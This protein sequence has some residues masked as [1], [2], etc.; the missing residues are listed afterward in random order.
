MSGKTRRLCAALL[1]VYRHTLPA[2]ASVL[3]FVEI[4]AD[5]AGTL[6]LAEALAAGMPARLFAG[7]DPD[8]DQKLHPDEYN[9][10]T[11]G[12]S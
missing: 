10:L 8:G 12:R 2:F 5:R 3:D 7:L 11:A 6:S 1:S 4:D 9:L